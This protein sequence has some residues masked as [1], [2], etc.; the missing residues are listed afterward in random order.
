[1][2]RARPQHNAV[3]RLV[4]DLFPADPAD[5]PAMEFAGWLSGSRRFRVFAEAHIDKIRKKLR[6]SIDADARRDL[7][8]ELAVARLLLADPRID[9][10]FEAYGSTKGGPDFTV[11]VRGERSFNLEVT[12]LRRPPAEAIDG[13][14]LLAKLRQLPP[15]APNAVLIAIEG[16]SADALDVAAATRRLRAR[17]DA[18]DDAFFVRR[19]FKGGRD[20]NLRYRRLGGVVVWCEAAGA[21]HRAAIWINPSARIGLPERAVAACLSRIRAG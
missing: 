14:P 20:F 13:G 17:A 8:V 15:G 3:D 6:L 11:A 18:R 2:T 9:L 19:G 12:R 1:M 16:D 21:N 7:R 5:P 4:L 10:A